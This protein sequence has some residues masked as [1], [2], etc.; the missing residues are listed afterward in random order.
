VQCGYDARHRELC[1]LPL[2]LEGW[3]T[4]QSRTH[5]SPQACG[6]RPCGAWWGCLAGWPVGS[7]APWA[8]HLGW[9][10]AT[11]TDGIL[12]ACLKELSC[13]HARC[14]LWVPLTCHRIFISALHVYGCRLHMSATESHWFSANCARNSQ[15][16][17]RA[18]SF[19][20]VTGCW[21]DR[22]G[23]GVRFPG[24]VIFLLPRTLKPALEP[25]QTSANGY[26]W[27]SNQGLKLTTPVLRSWMHWSY[28][29]TSPYV[30]MLNWTQEQLHYFPA[31]GLWDLRLMWGGYNASW[32]WRGKKQQEHGDNSTVNSFVICTTCCMQ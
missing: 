3:S 8:R 18:S 17:I 7:V 14:S 13:F 15:G 1:Y 4:L 24:E 9:T 2:P 28:A 19:G 5:G 11:A 29:S 25:A 20:I 31:H 16:W 12:V 27:Q 21:L 32:G 6:S 22:W 26:R 23:F 30:F 10:E